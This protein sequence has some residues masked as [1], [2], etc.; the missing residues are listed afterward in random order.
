MYGSNECKDKSVDLIEH[1]F[2]TLL[3]SNI[4]SFD[5]LLKQP[6]RPPGLMKQVVTKYGLDLEQLTQRDG[7]SGASLNVHKHILSVSATPEAYKCLEE[8]INAIQSAGGGGCMQSEKHFPDCCACYTEVDCERNLFRLECCG[9]VYCVE[10]IKIQFT[11]PTAIFPLVCAAE[12]CSQPFVIQDFTTLC[13][14]VK[15]SMQQLAEASLK[16]FIYANPNKIK[17]CLTPDCKM[18][19]MISEEGVKFLCGLCGVTIC[20]KCHVQYHD[21]LTC[22]M[23]QSVTTSGDDMIPWLMKDPNKRKR[24][25]KCTIPIEKTD[26]CNHIACPCGA[27]ICWV[28]LKHF[29]TP[30]SCY[31]HLDESHGSFV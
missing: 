23:Y 6:D 29:G 25:P 13:R 17:N 18:V 27:H 14:R 20:T 26:G 4:H 11:S 3:H 1:H 10:C 2:E 22:A 21:D 7:I 24:C 31:G 15:Y 30:Q 5:I 16:S 19:Y 12:Q 8:E 9:H 28:C